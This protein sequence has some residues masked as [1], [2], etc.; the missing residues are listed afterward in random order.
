MKTINPTNFEAIP[1]FAGDAKN[2]ERRVHAVVET[3]RDTRHKYA[4]EPKLGLFK[5]KLTLPEGMQWPYDYGFVPRT[6]ADDGDPL[7]ILVLNQIPTFTGCLLETRVLGIVRL[8]K[9]GVEND[10]LLAAPIVQP[11]VSQPSDTF[12][13]VAHIPQNTMDDICRFLVEYS[14]EEGNRMDFKEVGSR[15]KAMSA[16]ED[17]MKAYEK[18]SK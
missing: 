7:D 14:A 6:L 10:R 3:P 17:A 1:A 13:D 8:E 5:L 4:F 12:D 11:G 16:I 2:G 18:K 15:K 9:N